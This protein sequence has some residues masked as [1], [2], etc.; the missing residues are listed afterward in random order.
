ME[1]KPPRQQEAFFLPVAT[2]ALVALGLLI[3]GCSGPNP[4]P[5]TP[6]PPQNALLIDVA[7]ASFGEYRPTMSYWTFPGINELI[8]CVHS[9]E[10]PSD[11]T[12]DAAA[13]VKISL[14]SNSRLLAVDIGDRRPAQSIWINMKNKMST[15][16]RHDFVPML[17]NEN[18][19]IDS[20]KTCFPFTLPGIAEGALLT[21]LNTGR[22][23]AAQLFWNNPDKTASQCTYGEELT[24]PHLGNYGF[25]VGVLREAKACGP[26]EIPVDKFPAGMS[27]LELAAVTSDGN[28]LMETFWQ[29]KNGGPVAQCVHKKDKK[30]GIYYLGAAKEC[31]IWETPHLDEL[32]RQMTT[33]GS[34]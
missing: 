28:R 21:S 14:P 11:L 6:A 22:Y 7:S 2:T 23:Q 27:D 20:D 3:T 32:L 15:I 17:G 12:S 5:E 18:S 8:S 19:L 24:G 26:I 25:G 10:F 30:D 13:C 16:C 4:N 33:P 29:A 34:K 9:I 31:R 1:E